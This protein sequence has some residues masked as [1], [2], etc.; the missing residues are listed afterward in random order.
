MGTVLFILSLVIYIHAG[1]SGKSNEV[2][3]YESEEC[4][5]EEK[6]DGKDR[7]NKIDR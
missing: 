1:A 7:C 3:L 4:K 6:K 5:I 2:T